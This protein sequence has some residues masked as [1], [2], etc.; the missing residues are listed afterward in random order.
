MQNILSKKTIIKLIIAALIIIGAVICAV[1]DSFLYDDPIGKI[2][3]VDTKSTGK[4]KN[5][6]LKYSQTIKIKLQNTEKKGSVYELKNTYTTSKF[7]T[8]KYK[9]GQYVFLKTGVS[10]KNGGYGTLGIKIM[11]FKYDMYWAFLISVLVSLIVLIA[12]RTA[13]LILL[14]LGLNVV[15]FALGMLRICKYE[16]I[17]RLTV[18]MTLIFVVGTLLLLFGVS[19]KSLGAILSSLIT[20]G[21]VFSIYMLLTNI[22][23]RIQYEYIDYVNGN[24]PLAEMYCSSLVFSILGAVMDVAITINVAVAE[25]VNT[26]ENLTI[27]KIVA[28]VKEISNDIMGTMINVLFFTFIGGEIPINVLKLANGYN[29][30]TLFSN[31]EVFEIMRFLIGA[32]G[33]VLAVPV[34]GFVAVMLRR[35]E[36]R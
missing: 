20:V 27:K 21:I 1:N 14:S 11:S 17:P 33:V 23:G 30:M 10:K 24:E 28:S 35:K 13:I 19:K 8:T 9:K 31:G 5:G 16:D 25:I 6:D 34:S 7:R 12:G 4:G 36:I 29:M 3:S 32:I 18:G 2:I 15:V 22:S 26:G